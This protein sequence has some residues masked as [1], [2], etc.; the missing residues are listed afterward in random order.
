M[1]PFNGTWASEEDC[2]KASAPQVVDEAGYGRMACGALI[3]TGGAYMWNPQLNS[4][5]QPCWANVL[6]S[7]IDGYR[8]YITLYYYSKLSA[9]SFTSN[10]IRMESNRYIHASFCVRTSKK[11]FTN[12]QA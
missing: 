8:W 5:G 12:Y 7:T 4:H 11:F 6:A 10:I 1:F 2:V 3:L 9:V